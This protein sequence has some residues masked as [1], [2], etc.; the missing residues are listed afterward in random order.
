MRIVFV[1]RLNSDFHCLFTLWVTCCDSQYG[2]NFGVPTF[3]VQCYSRH[4]TRFVICENSSVCFVMKCWP[5]STV[6]GIL[7]QYKSSSIGIVVEAFPL[8]FLLLQSS[9][10]CKN[11]NRKSHLLLAQDHRSKVWV[12][13]SANLLAQTMGQIVLS[14]RFRRFC[15]TS[16]AFFKHI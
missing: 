6:S 14:I 4:V 5:T 12:F 1:K 15:L 10:L 3:R 13:S 9:F 8:V 16:T 11:F 2:S 7:H